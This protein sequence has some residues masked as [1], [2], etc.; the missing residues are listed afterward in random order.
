MAEVKINI[1]KDLLLKVGNAKQCKLCKK[2][3]SS[4]FKAVEHV[5]EVHNNIQ[6]IKSTIVE[7]NTPQKKLIVEEKNAGWK[8]KFCGLVFWCAT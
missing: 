2:I 3:F 5:H 8:C 6:E 4:E 1:K 7:Q